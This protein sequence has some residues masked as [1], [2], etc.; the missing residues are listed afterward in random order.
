LY[1][2]VTRGRLLPERFTEHRPDG[3]VFEVI[4]ELMDKQGK[5]IY[6][7]AKEGNH[8]AAIAWIENRYPRIKGL[9]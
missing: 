7:L 8:Q 4:P 2:L 6:Q 3:E 5:S 9:K 1:R